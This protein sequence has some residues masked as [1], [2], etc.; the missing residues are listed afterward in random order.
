MKQIITGLLAALAVF[1]WSCSD[2]KTETQAKHLTIVS[3][4]VQNLFDGIDNGNEHNEFKSSAG[5]NNEKYRA[6]ITGF[7]GIIGGSGGIN[8]D[9][10][11]LLEV[12]NSTVIEDLAESSGMD[13]RWSF[14]AGA[15]GSPIGLGVIS[16]LPITEAVAHSLHAEEGSIPR[17]V[18]EVR[19]DTGSGPLVLFVCHWK[20]KLGGERKTETLRQAGATIIA[21]RLEEIATEE[22][23]TPVI[24]M[25]D[26]N[27][28]YDEFA[29]IEAAYPCALLPDTD[30]AAAII[31]T[32]PA[33][34]PVRSGFQDF[35]VISGQKPPRAEFFPTARGVVYSPWLEESSENQD[36][37]GNLEEL[38]GNGSP[39]PQGSYYYQDRW[40]T[41]DHF[42]LNA[43]LFNAPGWQY[44]QFRVL[45]KPPFASGE[46]FP[47]K[48][49]PKT[50][51][52]FSDHLPIL[53]SLGIAN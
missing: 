37:F 47:R 23:E 7:A 42:L 36:E 19:I 38:P 52:G 6:R 50:G 4:N 24:I 34:R 15:P 35:L 51:S 3:W 31:R 17:P 53:L 33:R 14:F 10:L 25:G 18:A 40:E 45:A 26:L 30:D 9:I 21:R 22:P 29:R 8:P 44:E 41:I 49:N 46:G 11:A 5:W 20:S 1:L 48:Y 43:A 28:N 32:I 39:V 13:Y 16:R 2:V 27:V 12:E